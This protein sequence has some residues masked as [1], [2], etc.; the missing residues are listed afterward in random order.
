MFWVPC[1]G[2]MNRKRLNSYVH[3]VAWASP[4]MYVLMY[5]VASVVWVVTSKVLLCAQNSGVLI[6]RDGF[7]WQV[8]EVKAIKKAD[9]ARE[10]QTSTLA[11]LTRTRDS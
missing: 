1:D 8:C 3:R 7:W 5:L 10:Y 6:A 9:K 2:L 11:P 4:E